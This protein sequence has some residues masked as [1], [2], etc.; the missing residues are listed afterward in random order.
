MARG[1]EL[2]LSGTRSL[3]QGLGELMSDSVRHE[4]LEIRGD[5]RDLLAMVNRLAAPVTLTLFAA[6][7]LGACSN[8]GILGNTATSALPEKPRADPARL[9]YRGTLVVTGFER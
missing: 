7:M 2:G 9:R 5:S 3:L 4:S 1:N 6:L 8:D